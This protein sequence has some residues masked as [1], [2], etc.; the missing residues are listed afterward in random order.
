MDPYHQEINQHHIT[1]TE[2]RPMS[3]VSNPM[4]EPKTTLKDALID[5]GSRSTVHGISNIVTAPSKYRRLLWIAAFLACLG[6]VI[7]QLV[8]I[9]V[10]Y[11]SY[12]T[13]TTY[14]LEFNTEFP[15]ITICNNGYAAFDGNVVCLFYFISIKNINYLE[16]I[17][18]YK[19]HSS[20]VSFFLYKICTLYPYL[21]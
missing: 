1:I 9:F 21:K 17:I 10:L 13:K 15:A 8:N 11:T 4:T 3:M 5:I 18:H 6:L 7:Y 20:K 16:Y 12:E 14:S 19:I 2:S